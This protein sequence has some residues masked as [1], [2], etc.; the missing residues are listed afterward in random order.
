[1]WREK[2]YFFSPGE[3]ILFVKKIMKSKGGSFKK[4]F[5]L[6]KKL[7]IIFI[8]DISWFNKKNG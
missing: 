5:Y 3:Y 8:Q 1:M 6:W 2:N 7:R 4:D